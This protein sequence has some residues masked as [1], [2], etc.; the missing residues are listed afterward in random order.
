MVKKYKAMVLTP[1]V[2]Q[3]SD[4]WVTKPSED[5][6]TETIKC[7]NKYVFLAEVS[8]SEALEPQ[9]LIEAKAR[10]DWTL[11]EKAIEEELRTLKEAG[12]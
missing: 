12:T 2:Q 7:N 4:D 9:N 8:N 5:G 10:L 6:T 1:G 3:S 11:W